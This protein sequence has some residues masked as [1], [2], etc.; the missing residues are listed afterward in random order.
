[1]S[2]PK[3]GDRGAAPDRQRLR[4]TLSS[5]TDTGSAVGV[6][7]PRGRTLAQTLGDVGHV[8]ID[9]H[10]TSGT[11]VGVLVGGGSS[12][13]GLK[14]AAMTDTG[15][16]PGVRLCVSSEGGAAVGLAAGTAREAQRTT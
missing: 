6:H 15:L 13:A 9:V 16:E 7:V 3:D 12:L 2:E 8:S 11:A 10:S 14:E 4:V 5:S 1:M